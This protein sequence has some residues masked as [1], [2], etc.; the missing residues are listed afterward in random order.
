MALPLP[1]LDDRTFDTLLR[2]GRAVIP[3]RAPSWTDHNAHDPGITLVELFSYL[4]EQDIYRLDRT[5]PDSTRAFLRLVGIEP[6]PPGVAETVLEW[7]RREGAGSTEAAAG[8]RVTDDAGAV[9]FELDAPVHIADARLL[10]LA[11]VAAG[12]TEDRTEANRHPS[13]VWAPLGTSPAVG[14]ALYLGFD[15]PLGRGGERISLHMGTGDAAGDAETRKRLVA[16]HTRAREEQERWCPPG[17]TQEVPDWR[18]HYGVRTVWEYRTTAGWATLPAVDDQTRALTLTGFVR[19]DVPSDHARGAGPGPSSSLWAVRCRLAAGRYE[20][21]PALT[22]IGVHA[23]PA[24]HAVETSGW[25]PLGGSDG[26]AGQTFGTARTPVVAGSVVVRVL[27]DGSEDAPWRD[28]P[29]LDRIG[30]HDRIVL[31]EPERG[32]LIFG[33]GRRGRVPPAGAVLSCRYRVGGG[34]AGNVAAGTLVRAPGVEAAV[35]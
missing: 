5:P 8:Q 30:P 4:V 27:L 10:G 14:D 31:L 28:A 13:G 15:A 6:N 17:A 20:C 16:E 2:E 23:A 29:Y 24:R 18:Q 26:R 25:G 7:Q 32:R 1:R 19:F 21:P 9:A 11:T 34:A 33:D 35:V 12:R 22:R 3:R